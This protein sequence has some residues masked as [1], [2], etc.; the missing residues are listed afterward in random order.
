MRHAAGAVQECKEAGVAD[1][2][3]DEAALRSSPISGLTNF[4]AVVNE[5]RPVV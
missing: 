3:L 2:G 4:F 5:S 1:A